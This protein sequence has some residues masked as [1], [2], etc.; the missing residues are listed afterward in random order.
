MRKLLFAVTVA[1]ALTLAIAACRPSSN[2]QPNSVPTP[3]PAGPGPMDPMAQLKLNFEDNCATCHKPDGTGGRVTIKGEKLNV[4]D[5]TKG[6]ALRHSDKE[7]EE[8]IADGGDGMPQFKDKMTPEQ[9]KEMVAYL[10]KT[11]QGGK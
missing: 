8:Q 3:T 11:F 4:P 6:H 2:S 5:L 10:R 7:M 1:A 9:I